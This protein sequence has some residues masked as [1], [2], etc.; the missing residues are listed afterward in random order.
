MKV[1]CLQT[2]W[3]FVDTS[4]TIAC[5]LFRHGYIAGDSPEVRRAS[6]PH[7]AL[8]RSSQRARRLARA[9]RGRA[10]SHQVQP[11]ALLSFSHYTDNVRVVLHISEQK[12]KL[13]GRSG[14]PSAAYSLLGDP[15]L[16]R[17]MRVDPSLHIQRLPGRSRT[18]SCIAGLVSALVVI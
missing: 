9:H 7:W 17:A 2:M 10:R 4:L 5:H 8:R 16:W 15:E 18:P 13:A 3:F 1:G 14:T 12:E 6:R 11:F